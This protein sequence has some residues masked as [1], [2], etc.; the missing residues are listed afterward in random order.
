MGTCRLLRWRVCRVP[1]LNMPFIREASRPAMEFLLNR[2]RGQVM[3]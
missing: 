1:K 2:L 3:Q